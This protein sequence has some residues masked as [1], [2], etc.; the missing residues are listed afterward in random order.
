MDKANG[1]CDRGHPWTFATEY[2]EPNGRRRCRV[3]H[4]EAERSRRIKRGTYKSYEAR[5]R[6][7]FWSYVVQRGPDECWPW[8]RALNPRGYGTFSYRNGAIPAHRY[9]YIVAHGNV[10]SFTFVC[11]RCDNPPCC[12]PAHLFAGT[13]AENSADMVR[14]GRY[15]SP[16]PASAPKGE[17]NG[18]SKLTEGGVRELRAL[19]EEGWTYQQLGDRYGV[20]KRAA[21][22]VVKRQS[23]K[24]VT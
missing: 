9:A 16:D 20:T 18:C 23:W 12:N 21:W 6:E 22:L 14:K 11:H 1:H 17:A 15:R 24:H 3:C 10:D 8:K 7:R 19:R 13:P 4:R 5:A 2:H